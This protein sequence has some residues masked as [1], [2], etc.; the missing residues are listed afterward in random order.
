MIVTREKYSEFVNRLPSNAVWTPIETCNRSVMQITIK[1][2]L[3]AQAHY[4]GNST[5]KDGEISGV[6]YKINPLG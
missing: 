1:R 3:V 6:E 2:R 5:I 4:T